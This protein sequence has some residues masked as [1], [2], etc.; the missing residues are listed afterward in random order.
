MKVHKFGGASV[1]DGP[2]IRNLAEIVSEVSG[3]LVIVY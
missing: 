3:N 1:K 2:G